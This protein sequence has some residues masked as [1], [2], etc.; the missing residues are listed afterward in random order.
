MRLASRIAS[1]ILPI[2]VG[3]LL[4][5]VM[6][7]SAPTDARVGD[8]AW[9]SLYGQGLP[10]APPSSV[11]ADALGVGHNVAQSD[12]VAAIAISLRAPIGSSVQKLALTLMEAD[13]TAANL[14]AAGAAVVACPITGPWDP[15][16]N[17]DWVDVP[18]YDCT[19]GKVAGKRADNG[20]WTFDLKP[21]GDQW[22]DADFPLEQ[23]G[24]LLLIESSS[25]PVQVSFLDTSTGAFR[26]EFAATEPDAEPTEPVVV[27][28]LEIPEP[29]PTVT[30]PIAPAAPAPPATAEPEVILAQPTQ[31]QTE[32]NLETDTLGNLPWGAWLLI[33]ILLGGG[34]AVSYALGPGARRTTAVRRRAGAVTRALSRQA[35]RR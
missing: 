19:L 6:P 2:W 28:G 8:N 1:S 7:A 25:Q 5:P 3:V 13:A 29:V 11:P 10:F 14:G 35:Q 32:S 12:K 21:F 4:F 24:I 23:A 34:A 9:W 31:A 16:A 20:T 30:I 17:G 27:G 18:D 15:V 22:L 33:P 26:L